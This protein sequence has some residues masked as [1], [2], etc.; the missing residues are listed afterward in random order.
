MAD[1]P[2]S[3]FALSQ[4]KQCRGSCSGGGNQDRWRMSVSTPT[5]Q[6]KDKKRVFWFFLLRWREKNQRI[7][8]CKNLLKFFETVKCL[9][10]DLLWKSG[11]SWFPI[12]QDLIESLE[13]SWSLFFFSKSSHSL[14]C[15]EVRRLFSLQLKIRSAGRELLGWSSGFSSLP[16]VWKTYE[17]PIYLMSHSMLNVSRAA[18]LNSVCKQFKNRKILLKKKKPSLNMWPPALTMRLPLPNIVSV[19]PAPEELQSIIQEVKY[20][21]GLQSAKL[22][23]QL[24]RRDRL[25][26]K[27]QKNY[28][29]ITA[30]LQAVSQK[31]RKN[32]QLLPIFFFV[33]L[34][35]FSWFLKLDHH[36]FFRRSELRVQEKT[37]AFEWT[38]LT[39]PVSHVVWR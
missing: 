7:S 22:I 6:T 2:N 35:T 20:R 36:T 1:P 4:V 39:S 30:C 12:F 18:A 9:K 37:E 15:L 8:A 38:I 17:R 33:W 23:R 34:S 26:N 28:D 29:I 5:N 10:E 25:Y 24:R 21:S 16:G 19:F 31:R 13:S 32:M 3:V 11:K 27:L 14:V